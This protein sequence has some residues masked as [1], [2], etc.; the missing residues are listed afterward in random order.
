MSQD[1]YIS[2]KAL[3][4]L[5]EEKQPGDRVISFSQYSKYFT[6][7]KS[8]E[9][10]YIQKVKE[11]DESIHLVFGQ[12]I[13]SVI[14]DWLK[15]IYTESVR[16][17][18]EMDLHKMLLA[19]M[20]KEYAERKEKFGKHFSTPAELAS[21]YND[22][23]AILD[24]LRKKRGSYFTTRKV[25]LIAIEFPVMAQVHE[26][27]PT[28]KLTGFIDLIFYDEDLLKYIIID[29]KTSTKGWND[30]KKKDETTTDQVLIYKGHF[31]KLL[32]VDISK[33]DVKY[34]IVKRK[35]DPDSLWV[36]KRIQEFSPS[37]GKVSLNRVS[38][39]LRKFVEQCFNY[40]GT[41]KTDKTYPAIAG[42]NFKN[43]LFCKYDTR[44]DLCPRSNRICNE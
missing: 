25:K 11:S 40:D 24:Y 33:I 18:N 8:W 9:I 1:T 37:N 6:C 44:E 39:N 7:P 14:Q 15:M 28:I 29:I 22:G 41:Y 10:N 4:K 17:A 34:F 26:D 31:A 16:K 36:Q 27:Y 13:H 30:Y 2:T 21:F 38:K 42:K 5:V 35:I 3:A 20:T 32:N 19:A 12:A 23:C 43:C